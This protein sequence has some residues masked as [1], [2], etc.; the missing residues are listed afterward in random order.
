MSAHNVHLE[1][2]HAPV[3][4]LLSGFFVNWTLVVSARKVNYYI[5]TIIRHKKI[6]F[7]DQLLVYE[8]ITEQG[9]ENGIA[10]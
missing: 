6:E 2:N 10:Y 3:E 7:E 9:M 8:V 4:L 1:Y 5:R